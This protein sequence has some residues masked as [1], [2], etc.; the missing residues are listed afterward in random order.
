MI[1]AICSAIVAVISI[2]VGLWKYFGRVN[3]YKRK[4][5]DEAKKEYDDAIQSG[6][7]SRINAAIGKLRS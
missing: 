4:A 5:C 7:I 1:V 3:A 2:F 6:D